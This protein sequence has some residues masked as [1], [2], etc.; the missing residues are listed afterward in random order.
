MCA[1]CFSLVPPTLFSCC[2]HHAKALLCSVS[3]QYCRYLR[4]LITDT[5]KLQTYIDNALIP[6]VRAV[7]DHP[8]LGGWDIINEIE[9]FVIP[10]EHNSEP[11]FDTTILL[12]SGAGWAGH[13][14]SARDLLK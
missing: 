9:G 10:G 6:W 12:R 13:L 2:V 4:G 11:C 5:S 1:G 7:K 8:A 3:F 14:F